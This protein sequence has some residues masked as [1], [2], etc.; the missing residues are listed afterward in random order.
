MS[1]IC[2]ETAFRVAE[3]LGFTCTL[4]DDA[5]A[6]QDL[7]FKNELIHIHAVHAAFIAYWMLCL[8]ISRLQMSIFL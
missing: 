1:H 8:H 6:A 7:K 2:I 4:I 3:E 5:Y